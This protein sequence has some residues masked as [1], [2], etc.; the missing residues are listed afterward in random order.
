MRKDVEEVLFKGVDQLP[1]KD[2]LVPGSC[3]CG[4][5]YGAVPLGMHTGW[6]SQADRALERKM[7]NRMFIFPE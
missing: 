4:H 6:G 3:S 5:S 1:K 2:R 7:K